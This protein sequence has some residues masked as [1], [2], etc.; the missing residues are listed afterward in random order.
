MFCLLSSQGTFIF[1][2]VKY[3]P[4]KFSNSYVYPVWANI[5]GWFI[6][7]ISLSL[8]PLFVLCKV[9]RGKGILRQVSF[10]LL[11]TSLS[12]KYSFICVLPKTPRLSDYNSI[13]LRILAEYSLTLQHPQRLIYNTVISQLA[14]SPLLTLCLCFALLKGGFGSEF[15]FS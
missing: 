1:S 13:N 14:G 11:C 9:I 3:S 5:L 12:E 15:H 6:A 2:I 7:T 10:S 8:I 4:L